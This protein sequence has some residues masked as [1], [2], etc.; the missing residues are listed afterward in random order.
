MAETQFGK[1][2]RVQNRIMRVILHCDR[3]A[4]AEHVQFMSVK[5][6]LYYSVCI[7]I[8]KILK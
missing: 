3:Y 1:P 4:K 5:V 8:Y 7:F 2:R 6:R